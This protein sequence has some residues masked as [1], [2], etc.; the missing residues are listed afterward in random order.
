MSVIQNDWYADSQLAKKQKQQP[1]TSYE[2]S[3][4]EVGEKIYIFLSTSRAEKRRFKV[5]VFGGLKKKQKF[6][7]FKDLKK[8]KSELINLKPFSFQTKMLP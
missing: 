3:F 8:E 4:Y 7:L 5:S 1:V 6:K 2:V